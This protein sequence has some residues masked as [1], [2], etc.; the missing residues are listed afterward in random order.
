M[1]DC[2]VPSGKHVTGNCFF[3]PPCPAA[4]GPSCSMVSTDKNIIINESMVHLKMKH[5]TIK[6]SFSFRVIILVLGNKDCTWRQWFTMSIYPYIDH[7]KPI[8]CL[9]FVWNLLSHLYFPYIVDVQVSPPPRSCLYLLYLLDVL[10]ALSG[11]MLLGRLFSCLLH[12]W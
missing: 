4:K 1:I 8:I 2:A 10:L 5:H 12:M 6:T 3:P 9:K 11:S 7:Y